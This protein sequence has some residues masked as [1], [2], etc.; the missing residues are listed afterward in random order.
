MTNK[1]DEVEKIQ[2]RLTVLQGLWDHGALGIGGDI[3]PRSWSTEALVD[4][5]KDCIE[6]CIEGHKVNDRPLKSRRLVS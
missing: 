6:D 1:K 5:I 2:G 3:N 4:E